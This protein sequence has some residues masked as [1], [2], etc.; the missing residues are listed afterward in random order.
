MPQCPSGTYKEGKTGKSKFPADE[1]F[2]SKRLVLIFV[3]MASQ[4]IPAL[5]NSIQLK[6]YGKSFM[7]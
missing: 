1:T 5:C 2:K 7:F 3:S 6:T 4:C